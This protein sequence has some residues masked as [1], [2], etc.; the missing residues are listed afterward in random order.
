MAQVSEAVMWHRRLGHAN[1]AVLK[2]LADGKAA[3]GVSLGKH[4]E[5]HSG[6]RYMVTFIDDYSRI[7]F[8]YFMRSKDETLAKD[9]HPTYR[10]LWRIYFQGVPTLLNRK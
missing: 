5:T 2:K 6:K 3:S 4:T 9:W 7:S 1:D 10:Q 8:A